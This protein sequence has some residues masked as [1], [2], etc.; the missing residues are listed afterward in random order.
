MWKVGR[1]LVNGNAGD[2]RNKNRVAVRAWIAINS[3]YPVFV[4][5]HYVRRE[6][7]TSTS[8]AHAAI[9]PTIFMP[10]SAL[11]DSEVERYRQTANC[12]RTSGSGSSGKV[13]RWSNSTRTTTKDERN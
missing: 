4:V 11:Y 5:R 13:I 6:S 3:V 10:S 7:D 8:D 1:H 9:S 12:Q 2:Q